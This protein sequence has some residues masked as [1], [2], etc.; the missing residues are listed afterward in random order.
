MSECGYIDCCPVPEKDRRIKELQAQVDLQSKR[1]DWTV[2]DNA[3]KA[4]RITELEAQ[5]RKIYTKNIGSEGYERH[6][7]MLKDIAG[8]AL[9]EKEK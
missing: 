3:K 5:L 9:Q 4:I 1:I 8:E 2:S 6:C 7:M